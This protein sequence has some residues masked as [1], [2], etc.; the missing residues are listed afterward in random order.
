M[1][2]PLG[3][4]KTLVFKLAGQTTKIHF[5]VT[6][7]ADNTNNTYSNPFNANKYVFPVGVHPL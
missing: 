2:D 5:G 4:G 6:I 7:F 3:A 1:V